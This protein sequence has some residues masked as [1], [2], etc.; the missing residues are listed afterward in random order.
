MPFLGALRTRGRWGRLTSCIPPITVPAWMCMATGQDPGQLGIYGFRNRSDYSYGPLVTAT[1]NMAQAPRLWELARAAGLT[2]V[3][4]GWPLTYPA[5][6]L[7]GAMVAGPMSPAGAR[8][9]VWPASLKPRLA[10]WAG[11][12]YLFDVKDFRTAPKEELLAQLQAMAQRRF[13]VAQGLM[14]LYGPE[15]FMMVEMAPDRLHH[16]FWGQKEVLSA[17][18]ALLDRL[19]GSLVASLPPETLVL[20]VSDHGARS[21]EGGLAL[22]QWLRQ[23]GYLTLKE[24]PA[25]PCPLSAE[26]VDWPRTRAW[27]EGGYYGRIH[28]NIAGREPQGAVPAGQAYALAAELTARL[29]AL[30]APDGLPLGNRIFQPQEIY[31]AVNRVA[32]DLILYPGGLAW[33]ALAT[34][35]PEAEPVFTAGNDTGPDGANHAQEGVLIAALAGERTLPLAGQEVAGASLY[36]VFPTLAAWLG[37]DPPAAGPGAAW[38][39][40]R[41]PA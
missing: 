33:R 41:L 9:A 37:L 10:R 3:V 19:V 30:T 18:Y 21:L 14:G 40:L 20:V 35:W 17:H 23:E 29:E 38:K 34:V 27:A 31:L 24:P 32:P 22:N 13:A 36:D 28:L 2:S 25:E 15:L 26:L 5:A 4:L 7:K 8:D 1:A 11:G 12:E 6:P 16:A 39:W